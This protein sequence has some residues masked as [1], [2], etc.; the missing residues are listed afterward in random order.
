MREI[1]Q[2][3]AGQCGNQIGTK[4]SGIFQTSLCLFVVF[5]RLIIYLNN[6]EGM[7]FCTEKEVEKERKKH[8]LLLRNK[9]KI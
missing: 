2:V 5:V 4:V 8:D 7:R 3:Q 9:D 6:A 1:L